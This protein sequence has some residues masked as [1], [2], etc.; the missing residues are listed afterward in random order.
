MCVIRESGD[1]HIRDFKINF[2]KYKKYV[3]LREECNSQV[4]ESKLLVKI[5]ENKIEESIAV[6]DTT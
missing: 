5:P 4:F 1:C 6:Q 3:T 2:E